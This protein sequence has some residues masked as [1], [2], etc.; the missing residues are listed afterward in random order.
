VD[1]ERR[2]EPW[3]NIN[4]NDAPGTHH[5]R[6]GSDSYDEYEDGYTRHGASQYFQPR[7]SSAGRYYHEHDDRYR[8]PHHYSSRNYDR[9]P[10]RYSSS[11]HY[12]RDRYDR[13][14]R[15]DRYYDRRYGDGYSSGY[16][17]SGHR[18]RNGESLMYRRTANG[19]VQ[20]LRNGRE[21][22]GDKVRRAIGLDPKGVHVVRLKPGESIVGPGRRY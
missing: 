16:Y 20:V 19:D 4:I 7:M 10:H 14:P 2:E 12:D 22:V 17:S 13:Y 11:R 18:D 3:P 8:S 1:E 5:D 15:N 9:S 6:F 21:S